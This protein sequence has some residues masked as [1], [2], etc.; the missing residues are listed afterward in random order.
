MKNTT[1]WLK[2]TTN[3]EVYTPDG[4]IKLI[5]EVPALM[6]KDA[7]QIYVDPIDVSRIE[8]ESLAEENGLKPRE[9]PI[10]LLLCAKMIP[11][12]EGE[13][14]YQY[15]M[16]KMLFYLWQN[17]EKDG[18]EGAFPNDEFK[19]EKRG[20]VPVHITEDLEELKVKKLI[21]FDY[22]QWGQSEKESS[23]KTEL[24][25]KGNKL[26]KRLWDNIDKPIKEIIVET[27]TNLFFKTP[28]DVRHKVHREF[29][30]YKV[31]YV[32]EDID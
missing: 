12:K 32:E 24:T 14:F 23:L 1:V 15:H 28:I 26:A 7:K 13:I 16:N 19:A 18:L 31:K 17:L 3:M 8:M 6:H 20:P 22:H 21:N 25:E 27:K 29:P 11:F 2:T 4:T 30:E 5:K 10:L 9:I